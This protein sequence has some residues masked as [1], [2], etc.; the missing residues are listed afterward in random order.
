MNQECGGG[1]ATIEKGWT[2]IVENRCASEV[3]ER[4]NRNESNLDSVN[5][6]TRSVREVCAVRSTV[7]EGAE[8]GRLKSP[9]GTRMEGKGKEVMKRLRE[10]KGRLSRGRRISAPWVRGKEAARFWDSLR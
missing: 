4:G 10:R 9:I 5:N 1:K 6:A 7:S 8:L 3:A 2:E